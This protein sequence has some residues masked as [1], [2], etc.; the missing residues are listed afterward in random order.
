MLT[1]P[2]TGI[3]SPVAV[4]EG[5]V[6]C[7][8]ALAVARDYEAAIALGT[9]EGQ[10]LFLTVRGWACSWPYLAGRSH[11]ESYLKCTDP[12]GNNAIRIGD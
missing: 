4:L 1:N 7:A 8:E 3:A 9:P 2:R 5:S 10:G 11:A 6:D 12:T